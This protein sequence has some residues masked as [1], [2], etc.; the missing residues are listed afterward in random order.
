MMR[1]HIQSPALQCD[2]CEAGFFFYIF[3]NIVRWF[4]MHYDTL[5]SHF[6]DTLYILTHKL[7]E[8]IFF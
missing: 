1:H 3:S 6:S 2:T 4:F 7:L 5:F 8:N